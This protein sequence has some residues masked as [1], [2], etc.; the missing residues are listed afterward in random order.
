VSDSNVVKVNALQRLSMKPNGGTSPP[1]GPNEG[2]KL[3][4]HCTRQHDPACVT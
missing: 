2:F 3:L 1:H 4:A